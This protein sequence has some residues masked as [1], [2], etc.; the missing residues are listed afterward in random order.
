MTDF[1][2]THTVGKLRVEV[3]TFHPTDDTDVLMHRYGNHVDE[4]QLTTA[5]DLADFDPIPEGG[6]S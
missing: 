5:S 6:A 4:W 1:K 3:K 2:P